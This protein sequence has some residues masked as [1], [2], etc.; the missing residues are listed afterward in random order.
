MKSSY[1]QNRAGYVN[2]TLEVPEERCEEFEDLAR[3]VINGEPY[4]C[5]DEVVFQSQCRQG[6][7]VYKA[8]NCYLDGN[9][10]ITTYF[11][12]G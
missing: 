10:Y 1:N 6:E 12:Y 3:R 7:G 2:G 4:D 8:C 9:Y 11:S 5:I